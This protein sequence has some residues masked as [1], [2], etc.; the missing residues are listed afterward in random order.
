LTV[1]GP[2][3]AGSL[4]P[5][6][7]RT[8]LTMWQFAPLASGVLIVFAAGYV[9]CV[10][11][12]WRRHRPRPWPAVRLAAFFAGLA[13]IAVAAQSSIGVYDDVLFSDH[14]VQHV[15][16][17]MVAPPLLVAGRPVT[18]V[19]HA[20]GNPLHTWVRRV[21]RSRVAAA[22]TWP[23]AATLLY[24]A[25]VAGTHTP[26]VMD[27]VLGNG[28]VH[29][30]E[31]ALYLL[32]G[33]L[34]FLPVI[35]SE[36]IRWRL[37]VVGAYLVMLFA[38]MTD[39]FTGIVFTFQSGEVFAPYARTGRTWG[40][41]L[42]ADLHLGGVVMVAGS[43]L[44]MLVVAVGIGVRFFRGA[45]GAGTGLSDGAADLAAYNAYLRSLAVPSGGPI[46]PGPQD[47]GSEDTGWQDADPQEA[48]REDRA[49]PAPDMPP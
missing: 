25:V 48:G 37:S 42:T 12:V 28:A 23:P 30:A 34:F 33:Y 43:D 29:D 2:L 1:A 8:A 46:R 13:V 26:P 21:V 19:L 10:V 47:A 27:L 35:G 6:T 36:P 41:S 22:L 44:A 20:W 39:S 16:L 45:P 9:L 11:R 32:A 40:P 38:M 18:L 17:I 3:L 15:L 5:L 14:M 24:C 7:A 49:W 4:A 31:H